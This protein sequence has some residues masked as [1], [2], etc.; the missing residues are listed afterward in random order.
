MTT[1]SL[2]S[3]QISQLYADMDRLTVD[4]GPSRHERAIICIQ[5]CIANEIVTGSH[6]V[7]LLKG[8]GFNPRHVGKIL[9]DGAGIDPSRYHWRRDAAGSYSSFE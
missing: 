9:K 5:V 4:C 3:A 2:T 8:K 7:G 6:I 1:Q